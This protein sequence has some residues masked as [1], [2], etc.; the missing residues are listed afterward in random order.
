MFETPRFKKP[1]E[2]QHAKTSK[3]L[4]KFG[5]QHFYQ[6]FQSFWQRLS[7]EMFLLKICEI[8]WLFVNTLTADDKYSLRYRESLRQTIQVQ[9][10]KKQ[11]TFVNLMPN[12]RNL[13]HVL[14]ILKKNTIFIVHVFSKLYTANYVLT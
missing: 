12:F 9:L 8:L 5:W 10:S 13:F 1:F 2:S 3:T 4:V 7:W 14:N 6:I 11:K